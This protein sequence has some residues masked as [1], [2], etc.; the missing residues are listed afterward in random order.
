M[1][2]FKDC[3][4]CGGSENLILEGGM[5]SKSVNCFDCRTLGPDAETE[6]EAITAW[7]TRTG[8]N[9]E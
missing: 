2:E 1:S 5:I 4:F 7:N 8:D 3:P 6:N 9:N